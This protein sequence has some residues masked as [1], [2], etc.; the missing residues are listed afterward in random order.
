MEQMQEQLFKQCPSCRRKWS[1]YTEF[2]ADPCLQLIGYQVLFENLLDGLFLFNHSCG[3]TLAITV[4]TLQHLHHGPVFRERATG[5]KSCPGL[6]LLKHET[7]PC[8]AECEGAY[9]RSIMQTIKRW[10]KAERR[11]C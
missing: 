6:C 11:D 3:T 2:L 4:E 10:H 8:P 5:S 7:G 9:V 1:D